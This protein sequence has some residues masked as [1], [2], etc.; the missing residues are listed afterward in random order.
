M[1]Q[2]HHNRPSEAHALIHQT[3]RHTTAKAKHIQLQMPNSTHHTNHHHSNGHTT[4]NYHHSSNDY[5]Q[6]NKKSRSNGHAQL[7]H[8]EEGTRGVAGADNIIQVNEA[9]EDEISE[10]FDD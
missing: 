6:A 3:H 10:S 2:F 5:D 1:K 4:N 8:N 7:H 9:L